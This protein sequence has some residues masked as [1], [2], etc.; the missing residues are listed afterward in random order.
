M[1]YGWLVVFACL[2]AVPAQAKGMV[3]LDRWPW[4]SP[5]SAIEA[6]VTGNRLIHKTDKIMIYGVDIGDGPG[7]MAFNFDGGLYSIVIMPDGIAPKDIAAWYDAL[8]AN[9][10]KEYGPPQEKDASCKGVPQ[11]CVRNLWQIRPDTHALV[12]RAGE[13]GSERVWLTY[14]A[15]DLRNPAIRQD[16]YDAALAAI[17]SEEMVRS[18][19]W[20][21]MGFVPSLLVGVTGRGKNPGAFN[22]Y[23]A[24]LCG[25]LAAHGIG[26]AIIH[27]L[28]EDQPAGTW[29]ELGKADCP[30]L[31]KGDAT[32]PAAQLVDVPALAGKD[33]AAVA[34][35][36]GKPVGGEKTKYGPKK[37]YKLRG[38]DVEVVYIGGKADWLTITP[39]KDAPVPFGPACGQAIGMGVRPD[40]VTEQ[41]ITWTNAPGV[42]SV[43]ATASQG[44]VWY[45]Y[46]K[47]KTR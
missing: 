27:V 29:V 2:W 18:A 36:L 40:H 34:K 10:A 33:E 45:W 12:A 17:E 39:G 35:L 5:Q 3:D 13:H 30:Q 26:G 8:S 24:G 25:T 19:A 38:T 43:L 44:H 11:P 4:G 6:D 1:R 37:L 21:S 15:S 28:D 42:L 46:V 23:A 7:K 16:A 32:A 9:V 31:A 47:V 22:S 14:A 20:N 41:A